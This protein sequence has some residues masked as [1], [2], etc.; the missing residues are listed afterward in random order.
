[1]SSTTETGH[2]KNVSN[3][4]DQIAFCIGYGRN[5]NPSR[6]SLRI[7]DM[8]NQETEG[9]NA[10][11][12]VIA[13]RTAYNIAVNARMD[14]FAPLKSLATRLVN[15]LEATDATAELI[16]DAKTINKKIQGKRAS[17]IEAPVNPNDPV[18][19]TISTSQQSYD[20]LIQHFS[21]LI[22]LLQSEPSYSPNE[23]ALQIPTITTYRND[24]NTRNNDV[25]T[26]YTDVSNSRINRDRILY[27]L[28]TG[29]VYIAQECKKYIKS[30]FG[31]TSPEYAQ[32]KGIKFT[33][34]KI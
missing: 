8:Q 29:L 34:K 30:I 7:G 15:A 9:L 4:H 24:L 3:Y 6:A 27:T 25:S 28:D 1:M 22:E 10:L 23:T 16:K 11:A 20:Q 19:N 26:A 18:P 31:A 14:A 2:A 12:D 17:K 33:I 32:V 21:A 5:Y 13:K